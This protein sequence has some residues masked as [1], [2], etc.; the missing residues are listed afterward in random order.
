MD[1]FIV[2]FCKAA[3]ISKK[4]LFVPSVQTRPKGKLFAVHFIPIKFEI[5]SI[6]VNVPG[7]QQ[8]S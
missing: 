6:L 8:E 2:P 4:P 5:H 3:F 1:Y 7:F